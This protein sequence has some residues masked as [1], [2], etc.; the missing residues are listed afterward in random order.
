MGRLLCLGDL[1]LDVTITLQDPLAIG[2]DTPGRI[3]MHGGG[4][5]ANVAAWAARCGADVS[6]LGVVGDDQAADFLHDELGRNRVE[7]RTIR[8]AGT[9]TRAVAAIVDPTGERSMVSDLGT[10]LYPSLDDYRPGWLDGFGWLHLTGYT[11]IA[12]HSREFFRTITAEARRRH[13]P[14]SVDPS[15]AHLLG[16]HFRPREVLEAVAGATVLFPNRDEAEFLTGETDPSAAALALSDVAA[17][18]VVK[19][20]PDGAWIARRGDDPAHVD[21]VAADLV[22]TLGAGDAFAGGYLA[23]TVMGLDAEATARM[24]VETAARAVAQSSAR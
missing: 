11:L 19:C 7:V 6:F 13:V 9:R 22:S 24:A 10:T 15:A 2:S 8:R 23:A 21:A 20:G 14:F 18:V 4:S 12:A 3:E 1:N 16:A 17:T 5:A